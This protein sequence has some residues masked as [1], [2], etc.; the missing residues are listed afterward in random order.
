MPALLIYLRLLASPFRYTVD[1]TSP[2]ESFAEAM[3]DEDGYTYEILSKTIPPRKPLAHVTHQQQVGT[4][5][6]VQ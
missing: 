1:E 6:A 2:E 5:I 4:T 3:F